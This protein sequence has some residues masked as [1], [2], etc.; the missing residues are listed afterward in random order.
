MVNRKTKMLAG[1]L[2]LLGL[3]ARARADGTAVLLVLQEGDEARVA[4]EGGRIEAHAGA[5]SEVLVH[6]HLLSTPT[7]VVVPGATATRTAT[8][9]AVGTPSATHD[10]GGGATATPLPPGAQMP[11]LVDWGDFDVRRIPISLEAWWTQASLTPG[12]P[13]SQTADFGHVHAEARLPLGQEISGTLNFD[14]RVVLHHN[15]GRLVQLRI[16][17]DSGVRMR[18]PIGQT[19]AG[20]GTCAFNVPVALDTTKLRDGWREIR[21][22][23]ETETPDGKAF[24]NSGGIPFRVVNGSGGSDYNRWCGNKSLIARGWYDGFGYTNPV[25]ECVPL[26]PVSGVWRPRFYA[27]DG[28]GGRVIVAVDRAHA[29]PAVGPHPAVPQSAGLTLYD[30]TSISKWQEIPIDTTRLA[31]GWHTLSMIVINPDG[32]RSTCSLPGLC[33]GGTNHPAGVARIWFRVENGG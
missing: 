27:Q 13:T 5:G 15:P 20:G 6:C 25:I 21:I 11:Q 2:V 16:D 33:Q 28:N 12:D 23:A 8:A 24:L 26:A 31:D 3:T 1:A 19:C 22:R 18:I 17:D 29:V 14:V 32:G 9:A 7:P 30:A 4:C 10:H